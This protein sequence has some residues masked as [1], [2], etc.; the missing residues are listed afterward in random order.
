MGKLSVKMQIMKFMDSFRIKTHST[1]VA[2]MSN[3]D[4]SIEIIGELPGN[5][6]NVVEEVFFPTELL[7][8]GLVRYRMPW[9]LDGREFFKWSQSNDEIVLESWTVTRTVHSLVKE[10]GI[11]VS[12]NI[13][14]KGYKIPLNVVSTHYYVDIKDLP[15]CVDTG[16]GGPAFPISELTLDR[17]RMKVGEEFHQNGDG[18][19]WGH[20]LLF[21]TL[22]DR[23]NFPE[24]TLAEF[25]DWEGDM[26]LALLES[27]DSTAPG[28]GWTRPEMWESGLVVKPDIRELKKP[29]TWKQE[30]GQAEAVPGD[31][32]AEPVKVKQ[33][34][35]SLAQEGSGSPTLAEKCAARND[36]D[37]GRVGKRKRR[38][39]KKKGQRKFTYSSSRTQHQGQGSS[40]HPPRLSRA[41]EDAIIR[42]LVLGVCPD[43]TEEYID[44]NI[45][46]AH[47][48]VDME[49]GLPQFEEDR[50]MGWGY[51][52]GPGGWNL[53]SSPRDME[54]IARL[55]EADL[56]KKK[57]EREEKMQRE[58]EEKEKKESQET[59]FKFD[60][61]FEMFLSAAS[62]GAAANSMIGSNSTPRGEL[63]MMGASGSGSGSGTSG[64]S[65]PAKRARVRLS[66]SSGM[67]GFPSLS[68]SPFLANDFGDRR[69]VTVS[70][71]SSEGSGGKRKKSL[72]EMMGG[73][74]LVYCDDGV[75]KE[76]V[77]EVEIVDDE[78]EKEVGKGEVFKDTESED[79]KGE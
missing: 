50:R 63:S 29:E 5:G 24:L 58:K 32:E 54:D 72:Y 8:R 45:R 36:T 28:Q 59:I 74:L 79:E 68:T 73:E 7:E 60:A 44:Y 14:W 77:K 3:M 66:V 23:R 35:G 27:W 26:I 10:F 56:E 43:A 62:E 41:Q 30:G 71:S 38:R 22:V 49:A 64:S 76:K 16:R 37:E 52:S 2:R 19:E 18:S 40:V 67:S 13:P 21:Y 31:V 75:F 53:R 48:E 55:R 1:K 11:L 42:M 51:G 15:M 61:S 47:G 70:S 57:K 65:A 20:K 6:N 17:F 39:T 78:T 33:D 46:Q 12:M 25:K 34:R 69:V 4:L 9:M